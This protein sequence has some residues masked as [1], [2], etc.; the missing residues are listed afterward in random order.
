MTQK[1]PESTPAA[2]VQQTSAGLAPVA[3]GMA[4]VRHNA[5]SGALRLEE[6]AAQDLLEALHEAKLKVA[7]LVDESAELDVPL[8][9]GDNF[10]GQTMSGRLQEAASGGTDAALPVLDQFRQMLADLELTVRAA[11]GLYQTADDQALQDIKRA[12]ENVGMTEAL[13][14]TE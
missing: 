5:Q 10:V 13:E 3:A 2:F 11:A 7:T 9:L 6:G 1:K 12:A 14:V 4:V 8:R